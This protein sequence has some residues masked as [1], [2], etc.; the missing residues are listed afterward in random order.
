M[1]RPFNYALAIALYLATATEGKSL[2][3]ERGYNRPHRPL[4]Q[5]MTP[6]RERKILESMEKNLH[7][8][9][10]KGE[11][12]RAKNRKTA[13]KIYQNRHKS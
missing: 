7:D 5:P 3:H 8:F 13:L 10:I 6:E 4:I 9:N 12:I 2:Y 11:I 1:N